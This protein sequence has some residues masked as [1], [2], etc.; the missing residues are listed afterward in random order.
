MSTLEICF[1]YDGLR[2]G[3]RRHLSRD[4]RPSAQSTVVPGRM[5]H[6]LCQAGAY[7]AARMTWHKVTADLTA[8]PCCRNCEHARRRRRL[9]APEGWAP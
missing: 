3:V 6:T 4:L 7:D 9:D 1:T 5:G 2:P 8:L